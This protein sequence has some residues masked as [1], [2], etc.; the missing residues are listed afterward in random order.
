MRMAGVKFLSLGELMSKR[1]LLALLATTVAAPLHAASDAATRFG[2]RADVQDI[3]LSPDGKHIAVIEPTAGAGAA[4]MII[5]VDDGSV[6]PILSSTGNP[7]RLTYCSWATN[8]RIVCGIYMIATGD[9]GQEGFTR[10]FASDIDGKHLVQVSAKQSGVLQGIQ[11]GGGNVIDLLPDRNDGSVLATRDFV[12]EQTTGTLAANIHQ[13]LGVEEINTLTLKRKLVESAKPSALGYISDGHGT[14]RVMALGSTTAAG[15][16]GSKV[17]YMY[18]KPN[19]KGW[20][21]LSTATTDSQTQTGFD[22]QAVDRDK[23]IV[24]GFDDSEG[25]RALYSISLDG[26]LTR[27]KIYGRDDV[28]LDDLIQIGRDHRTVGVSYTTDRPQALFFDPQ[29]KTLSAGLSKAL[30]GLPLVAFAD[31]SADESKLLLFA[32][33][34]V[35]PG[36]YYLFDKATKHLAE[37]MP[38]R[39]ALAA[40]HLAT[41]SSITFKAADG[42]PIPAYLTLPPGSDGKNLP[43][44]VLPHGGPTARDRWGFDWLSQFF[45]NRGYAVLQPNFRG[46]SGYGNQWFQHNGFKSWRTA[47]GDVNDAGRWLI[48]QKIADPSKLAIFGASYGGYAALQSAVLDPTLYKAIVAWAPVTDLP[49]L[50]EEHRRF[51]DFHLVEAFVGTGEHLRSGSPAQNASVITAPVLLFHG[52]RDQNVGIGESRLMASRLRSAHKRVELVEF[53]GLDHYL[54]DSNVRAQLLD[55][56][57]TFLRLNLGL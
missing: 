24:Y 6:T 7:D 12:P 38:V 25:R 13:G 26:D 42:T 36:H 14:V 5:S 55:K 53:K 56:A 48:A 8:T 34:D 37:V 57:D 15:Y 23:N 30:P 46:S 27:Q 18:R 29:L 1:L 52:D 2:A 21:P 47:I 39:S 40:T 28:D 20:R 50:V 51:D 35:D 49:S 16:A 17:S 11:Q 9:A 43:A 10:M 32:G 45:A 41:V 44:I 3:S 31:A 22:A 19:E 4:V 54:D 33:S